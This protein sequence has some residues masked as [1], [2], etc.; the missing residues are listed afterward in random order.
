MSRKASRLGRLYLQM[1]RMISLLL[2]IV[3]GM[4]IL[5]MI[6]LMKMMTLNHDTLSLMTRKINKPLPWYIKVWMK[7]MFEK[8]ANVTS[9]KQAW[10]IL[11]NSLKG[12]DKVKKIFLQ[13]LWGEFECL[14]MKESESILD[15]FFKGVGYYTST[16][17][18]WWEFGWCLC[19]RKSHSIINFQV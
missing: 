6:L 11:K 14:H 13:T 19:S 18:I 10:E 8:V 9:S 5:L 4:L 2:L 15:Y 17:K 3:M 1:F 16:K 12:V 7:T